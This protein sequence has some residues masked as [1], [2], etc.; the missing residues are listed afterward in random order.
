MN[1]YKVKEYTFNLFA[2][3][4]VIII[5]LLAIFDKISWWIVLAILVNE[6]K[7]KMTYKKR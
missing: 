7:I 6:I 4:A 2:P 5:L 1:G 3:I